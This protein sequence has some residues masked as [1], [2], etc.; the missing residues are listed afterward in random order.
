MKPYHTPSVCNASRCKIMS[1][2]QAPST[3]TMISLMTK[4][5]PTNTSLLILMIANRM[6][7]QY[8]GKA[9]AKSCN[10]NS[11]DN[12]ITIDMSSNLINA[13]N[14]NLKSIIK[15]FVN[16][17]LLKISQSWTWRNL[18]GLGS[19]SSKDLL[20]EDGF[21]P[22]QYLMISLN[23][24]PKTLTPKDNSEK[25]T[26]SKLK[27]CKDTRPP[28]LIDQFGKCNGYSLKN[29]SKN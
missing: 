19:L 23:L 22:C 16:T 5:S 7:C 18:F 25:A 13:T 3:S 26:F 8:F 9:P 20:K 1:G 6:L 21:M 11:I 28:T 24:T 4:L 17:K 12:Y 27:E 15:V 14:E 10:E 2:N 29:K